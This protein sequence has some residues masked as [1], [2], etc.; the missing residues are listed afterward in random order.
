MGNTLSYK[1]YTE[2]YILFGLITIYNRYDFAQFN[3]R[4][5]IGNLIIFFLQKTPN[6]LLLQQT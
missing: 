2:N 5:S 6:T 4:D 3:Y 1:W